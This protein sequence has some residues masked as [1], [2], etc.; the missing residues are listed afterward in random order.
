MFIKTL[1]TVLLVVCLYFI[2]YHMMDKQFAAF[3]SL[4]LLISSLGIYTLSPN[5]N[6]KK[7]I[8]LF[9]KTKISF[10]AFLAL[11]ISLASS[12]NYFLVILNSLS[13][14]MFFVAIGFLGAK[15][16]RWEGWR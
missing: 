16:F 12:D 1:S 2:I 13:Y 4:L 6:I 3:N 7:A 5:R 9:G 15:L 8:S 10:F 14:S 11:L